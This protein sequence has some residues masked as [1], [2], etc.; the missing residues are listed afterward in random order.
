[1]YL[2]D[3]SAQSWHIREKC[4]NKMTCILAGKPRQELEPYHSRIR[5]N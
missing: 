3:F 4:P 2:K 5:F 1:M